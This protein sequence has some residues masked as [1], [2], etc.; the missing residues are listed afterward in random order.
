MTSRPLG[1]QITDLSSSLPGNFPPSKKP[2]IPPQELLL[3]QVDYDLYQQIHK[4]VT[5]NSNQ[6]RITARTQLSAPEIPATGREK[7]RDTWLTNWWTST[8]LRKKAND[9][10]D[11]TVLP[12]SSSHVSLQGAVFK[13]CIGS[14]PGH[15]CSL[16]MGTS[17]WSLISARTC[18]HSPLTHTPHMAGTLPPL[19]E[20]RSKESMQKSCYKIYL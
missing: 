18:A 19:K 20:S 15:F 1:L 16:N 2:W 8:P 7:Y 3:Q 9:S 17:S 14:C 6:S 10:E 12:A 13:S 5:Q 11:G 4:N